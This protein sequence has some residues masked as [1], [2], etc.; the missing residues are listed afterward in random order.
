MKIFLLLISAT[1]LFAQL[2]PSISYTC[3]VSNNKIIF[4]YAKTKEEVMTNEEKNIWRLRKLRT[5]KQTEEKGY[6]EA[7]VEKSRV[8]KRT[9]VAKNGTYN[10]EI[11][12]TSGN[13]NNL[14]GRCGGWLTAWTKIIK[15][16]KTLLHQQ[17]E[18][19]CNTDGLIP[20]LEFDMNIDKVSDD[21]FIKFDDYFKTYNKD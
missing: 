11:G 14:Y 9:C 18:S 13:A 3:D 2:D 16:D 10:I 6:W 12:V 7:W 4:D 19:D 17:F 8:V 21:K 5:V 20:H 1:L 15:E